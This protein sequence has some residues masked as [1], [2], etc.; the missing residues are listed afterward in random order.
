MNARLLLRVGIAP[1]AALAISCVD[2]APT[3]TRQQAVTARPTLDVG[4]IDSAGHHHSHWRYGTLSWVQRPDLGPRT[5][6][7]NYRN[8][9]RRSG[10]PGT[11]LDGFPAVGDVILEEIGFTGLDFGD[12]T[13]ATGTLQ[14]VVTS[15]NPAED[16]LFVEALNPGTNTPGI[17]HTYAA[18]GSYLATSYSCCRI[19]GLQ[20]AGD[21][22]GAST[23][24]TVGTSNNSPVSNMVPIVNVSSGGTQTWT[25]L[26]ADANGDPLRFR[27]A[28]ATETQGGD[29]PP[30]ISI[31][32]TTGV[33]SWNTTGLPLGLYWTQQAVDELNPDGSVKGKIT[34]D[35]LINLQAATVNRPPVFTS[36]ACN[37]T[38]SVLVGAPLTIP[39]SAS[40]PDATDVVSLVVSGAPP[41][42]TFTTT[43]GNPAQGTLTW[44][45][46][47]SQTGPR[48]ITF[49]ASDAQVGVNCSITIVASF[50]ADVWPGSISLSRTTSVWVIVLS[51]PDF[52][53]TAIDLSSVRLGNGVGTETP[54]LRRP[55]GSFYYQQTDFN[56][57]GHLD[58]VLFFSVPDLRANGDLVLGQPE[59]V[60]TGINSTTGQF[61]AISRVMPII[62][63]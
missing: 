44:T 28:D 6:Q 48:V 23:I 33:V 57:D 35:Y 47:T 50:L 54:M 31:D 2:Q 19:S 13:A 11:A 29:Q 7:F 59:L 42:A 4:P 34:V 40:D 15:I 52:D 3:A 20:N 36:P 62:T 56:K 39:V 46:L 9:F 45:P 16:W 24:V 5:V 38:R 60:L 55:D 43:P 14:Y 63:P 22:Y 61:R 41:G 26:A 18:N 12:G 21:T 37:S 49:T 32:P 53:A 30:G 58:R 51:T 27:M 10:Y 1:L 25:L 17:L 8:A